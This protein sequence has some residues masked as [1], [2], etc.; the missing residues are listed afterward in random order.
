M[1]KKPHLI[2]TEGLSKL[3]EELEQVFEN[4]EDGEA[5]GT[6]IVRFIPIERLNAVLVI[7]PLRE[8]LSQVATWV[9]RLDQDVG[10]GRRL[11]VYRVQNGRA[12]EIADVLNQV[13]A[14][15]ETG[16]I[17]SAELAPGLAP[18][19]ISADQPP[20]LAELPAEVSGEGALPSGQLLAPIG[21]VETGFSITES[22]SIRVIPDDINNTLLIL[23]TP[24]EFKQVKA[25]I[26][27]LDV[28][29]L[30]VLI[31][32][33]IAEISL[34]DDLEYGVQWTFRNN[35][36][37]PD[38]NQSGVG[39]FTLGSQAAL[40]AVV[41]GFSYSIVGSDSAINATLNALARD[42]KLNI[43]SSPSLMVLNNQE[44]NI[45]V[46]D[47]VPITTQQQ[48]ATTGVSSV[49]NNIEYRDTGVL[50][51]VTPRVNAGGLVIMDIVQEV[52][53]VAQQ[54]TAAAQA[55]T[56]LTPTIQTRRIASSVAV[57]S[58][59][60][61]VLGGLIRENK[62]LIKE[63][64]PGLYKLPVI[65]WL[66]GAT[67]IDRTRVELVVLITPRAVQDAV[68]S[69]KITDEFVFKMRSLEPLTR[70]AKPRPTEDDT[71][72]AGES[73]PEQQ[74]NPNV[75]PAEVDTPSY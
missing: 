73:L 10:V 11:F 32:A 48:Q 51:T 31:E 22:T 4:V 72:T 56:L 38:S 39:L 45:Q 40:N 23:A 24:P 2:T 27:Q 26:E 37:G 67:R 7:T 13:F 60:T 6:E 18:V 70:A 75:S 69:Q 58:G 46:G 68:T 41:P 36:L 19:E 1:T 57:Q 43:I 29:P 3:T 54:E 35:N 12:T 74:P 62:N 64:I 53:N 55:A 71:E 28:V 20:P 50:L 9:D 34:T 59:D 66:F 30:Q 52:S 42:S 14:T 33:T 63:G 44:A 47:E 15:E 5:P 49:V 61:I 25:A 8:I 16:T 17:Q 65:G 21:T